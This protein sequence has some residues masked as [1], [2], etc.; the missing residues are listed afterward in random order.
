MLGHDARGAAQVKAHA[1]LG[2]AELVDVAAS[3]NV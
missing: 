2:F 3:H 1:L